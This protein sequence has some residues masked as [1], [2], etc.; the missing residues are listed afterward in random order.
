MEAASL[1]LR[2]APN[3]CKHSMTEMPA[4]AQL[5]C[6]KHQQ[7]KYT[8][9]VVTTKSACIT[10]QHVT[11]THSPISNAVLLFQAPGLLFAD[12]ALSTRA[13]QKEQVAS[14][15]NMAIGFWSVLDPVAQNCSSVLHS[16]PHV[17][18]NRHDCCIMAQ[19]CSASSTVSTRADEC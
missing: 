16:V 12:I 4:D 1:S 6:R 14:C 19:N 7:G 8:L 15:D 18:W 5:S 10:G 2:P 3:V 9:D 11:P 13:G 17:S